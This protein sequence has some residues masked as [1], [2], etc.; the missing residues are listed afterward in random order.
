MSRHVHGMSSR[1]HA[2]CSKWLVS[3]AA[4][5]IVGYA[6]L[7]GAQIPPPPGMSAPAKPASMPE[8]NLPTTAGP[9]LRSES[10]RGRVVVIRFWASW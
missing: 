3:F 5:W 10:L 9:A 4:S 8:F 2:R 1:R 6:S 7:A